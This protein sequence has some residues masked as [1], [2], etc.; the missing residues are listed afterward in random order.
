MSDDP[1]TD[2]SCDPNTQDCFMPSASSYAAAHFFL[3]F[4][5]WI[6]GAFPAVF[7]WLYFKPDLDDDPTSKAILERNW[8]W[9]DTAWPLVIWGHMGMYGIPAFLGLFTW[10]GVKFFD[11]IFEFW[12]SAMMNYVGTIMHFLGMLSFLAGAGF[13]VDN[14]LI[15]VLTGWMIAG[16]YTVWTVISFIWIGATQEKSNTYMYLR[17]CGDECYVE[18]EAEE[19]EATEIDSDATT[20]LSHLFNF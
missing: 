10:F 3:W 18:V 13:W 9:F 16:G 14:N 5:T 19:D 15:S 1:A 12:M 6:N 2:M 7:W 20:F 4:L 11:A 17:H 8:W